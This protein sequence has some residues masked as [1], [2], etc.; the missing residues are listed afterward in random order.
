MI[1]DELSKKD[2]EV[3]SCSTTISTAKDSIFLTAIYL[4][5]GSPFYLRYVSTIT[6][7]VLEF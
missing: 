4:V 6:E 5:V 3:L 1:Y 2:V 7:R